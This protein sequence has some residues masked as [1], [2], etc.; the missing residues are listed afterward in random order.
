[1]K[2]KLSKE[3]LDRSEPECYQ[4]DQS[5]NASMEEAPKRIRFN[6]P[7]GKRALA[8]IEEIVKGSS[9]PK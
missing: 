8:L 4:G 3:A 9:H 5:V 2:R 1:M 7:Q 6:D